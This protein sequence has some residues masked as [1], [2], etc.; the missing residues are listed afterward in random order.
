M[1]V[2]WL[3]VVS[4]FVYTRYPIGWCISPHDWLND[5]QNMAGRQS[6][7]QTNNV[8]L[9]NIC[10]NSPID[11]RP[12]LNQ[13]TRLVLNLTYNNHKAINCPSSSSKRSKATCSH[14]HRTISSKAILL[15]LSIYVSLKYCF[16]I[17]AAY[18]FPVRHRGW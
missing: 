12:S 16:L 8:I 4:L 14:N 10:W 1:W 13:F 9:I 18:A 11:I 3:F 2:I 17:T 7:H 5:Y 15:L 6:F